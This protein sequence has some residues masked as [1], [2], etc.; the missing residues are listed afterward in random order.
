MAVNKPISMKNFYIIILSILI[1]SCSGGSETSNLPDITITTSSSE[2]KE[3]YLKA[4]DL[5]DLRRQATVEER[6]TLLNQAITLDP[7]FLLAKASL[8]SIL[9]TELNTES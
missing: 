6:R 2:A 4:M 1:I 5:F 3:A 8:Y 9:G 7:E